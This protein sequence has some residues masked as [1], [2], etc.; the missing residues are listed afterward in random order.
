MLGLLFECANGPPLLPQA[1][2]F[3]PRQKAQDGIMLRAGQHMS[4]ETLGCSDQFL[5]VPGFSL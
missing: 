2:I 3:F 4:V 5:S 1:L